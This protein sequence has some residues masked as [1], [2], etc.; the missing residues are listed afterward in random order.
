ME[1]GTLW[2]DDRDLPEC[3]NLVE[4]SARSRMRT[5]PYAHAAV[6][7]H[8]RMRTQQYAHTS[9]KILYN[10]GELHEDNNLI[11]QFLVFNHGFQNNFKV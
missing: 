11:E 9:A 1:P 3:A 6:P 4:V 2:S 7:S 8:C 10:I 5:Q